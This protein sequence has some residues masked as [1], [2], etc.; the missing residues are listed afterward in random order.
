MRRMIFF[1]QAVLLICL[2]SSCA[3]DASD[4]DSSSVV[5][6]GDLVASVRPHFVGFTHL[7]SGKAYKVG[8]DGVEII[9]FE[10]TEEVDAS[11]PRVSSWNAG[12]LPGELK[13]NT[14]QRLKGA[15]KEL[16]AATEAGIVPVGD[17]NAV[18]QFLLGTKIDFDDRFLEQLKT[19]VP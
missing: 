11:V 2:C 1:S 4:K 18:T 6:I 16:V 7:P 9:A 14:R 15:F 5:I 17:L 8:T 3:S 13:A 12:V 10:D 19:L